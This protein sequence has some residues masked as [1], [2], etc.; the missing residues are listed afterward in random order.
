M[1]VITAFVTFRNWVLS[2]R[3]ESWSYS[4]SLLFIS[5]ISCSSFSINPCASSNSICSFTFIISVNSEHKDSMDWISSPKILSVSSTADW[6]EL[7]LRIYRTKHQRNYE[8]M[9]YVPSSTKPFFCST[10]P[11]KDNG[12]S[13]MMQLF[14]SLS[15]YLLAS[16][17]GLLQLLL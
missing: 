10:N 7:C 3:L 4:A 14:L 11:E 16:S 6:A 1:H 2:S 15:Y 9:N 8:I 17:L 13:Q 12:L 5:A